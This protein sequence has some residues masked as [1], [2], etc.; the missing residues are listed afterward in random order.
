MQQE[1]S[2]LILNMQI[3]WPYGS[4]MPHTPGYQPVLQTADLTSKF[5]TS[6]YR[7]NLQHQGQELGGGDRRANLKIIKIIL[8]A[9]D[10]GLDAFN[11]NVK[12]M[13]TRREFVTDFA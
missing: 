5:K 12:S 7:F 11:K 4:P 3:Y 8:I 9:F 13:K 2:K 10:V 1:T 6:N